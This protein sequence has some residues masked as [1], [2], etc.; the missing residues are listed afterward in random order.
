[1]SPYLTRA[2]LWTALLL[3]SLSAAAQ[4][5]QNLDF[6]PEA[7]GRQ[8]L[9]LWSRKQQPDELLIRVDTVAPAQHGRGSLLLDASRAEEPEGTSIY[10]SLPANDS[11]RGRIVTVSAWVRTESFQGKAWLRAYS[12][13]NEE[14]LKYEGSLSQSETP[15][16]IANLAP[17]TNWQRLQ[18]Q[19]S[20]SK[21]A[22]NLHMMLIFQGRGRLWL[23]NF[24]VQWEGG[25]Y[26]DVPLAGTEPLLLPP[27]T[28]LPD[29]DF[30]RRGPAQVQLPRPVARH[31]QLDSTVAR[32]G[33]R[34]LRVEAAAGTAPVYLGVVP[35]D[36]LQGKT[37][38]V[39]GYVRYPAP[40][41]PGAVPPMLLHCFL[42]NSDRLSYPYDRFKGVSPLESHTLP[43]TAAGAAEWQRFETVIPIREGYNHS[44]LSL[45]LQ[46][47]T[48]PVWLDQVELLADGRPFT[49]KAPPVPG[50]PTAVELAWLRKAAVPL[51]TTVP[52]GDQKDLA[53]FGQLVGKSFLIGLGEVTHGSHEQMQL[54]HRLFRYLVEQKGARVLA[55]DADLGAC[56]ALN[57]Y[58]QTGKGDPQQLV[59]ELATWDTAEMLAL[60]RWMRTYNERATSKLQLL[61]IDI[62]QAPDGLRYLRQQLPAQPGYRGEQLIALQKQLRDLPDAG[63]A[64][65]PLQQPA[66]SDPRLD[67]VRRLLAEVHAAYDVPAKLR[68]GYGAA[69]TE[70]AALTQLLRMAEQFSVYQTL[71]SQLRFNYRAAC[72]AENV[73]WA[74][75]QADGG[76]VVV[77]ANNNQVST[78]DRDYLTLGQCLRQ[79]YSTNYVVVGLAFHEGSFRALRPE[80]PPAFFTASAMPAALGSYEH[81]FHAAALPA[82]ATLLDLRSPDLLPGTQWLYE[83]LLLRDGA[84]KPYPQPFSRHSL[85][86]EFDA[87]LYLLKSTPA[88]AVR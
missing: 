68:G 4:A 56:L 69:P 37:L 83:N 78:Y 40:A 36:S 32:H 43:P 71:D 5:I 70:L 87:L 74:R 42:G 7:N 15:A 81:Y 33:R 30:E 28:P 75:A 38:T 29:W 82:P 57:D 17:T 50:Q 6:E 35:L 66:K 59:A 26:R 86:R 76:R 73:Q 77:W 1:M 60:V 49:P 10:F 2:V 63:L 14:S 18:V 23:D 84:L 64:L 80:D 34:S 39:R 48:A 72:L 25:K 45:L 47:G 12:A 65:N 20:V 31:W 9:L 58:L 67:A 79:Q 62:K 27:G 54:K 46:P 51:R 61:G 8:P 21:L 53:A 52:E 19:V 44:G 85:R 3:S 22:D 16:N 55:L 13:S 88:Q 24:E 11:L 41:T